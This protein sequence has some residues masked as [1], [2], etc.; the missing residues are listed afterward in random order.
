M[1]LP[2]IH[3]K[4]D[5]VLMDIEKVL[6]VCK[7]GCWWD[8]EAAK[9]SWIPLSDVPHSSDELLETYHCQ[10]LI[11]VH[12]PHFTFTQEQSNPSAGTL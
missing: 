8:F 3:I 11:S 1:T 5:L 7:L 9:N 12:P 6:D 4:P 10:H 2:C